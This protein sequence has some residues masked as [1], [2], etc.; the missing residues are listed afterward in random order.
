LQLGAV[1]AAGEFGH[2]K[3]PAGRR[4]AV[5][6]AGD[7]GC[8]EAIAKAAGRW[9][10][11][12]GPTAAPSGHMRDVVE[13][14]NSGDADDSPDDPRQ[15]PPRRRSPCRRGNLLNRSAWCGRGIWWAPMTSRGG[16]A[17]KR[18][19]ANRNC[20]GHPGAAGGAVDV[21]ATAPLSSAAPRWCF[22]HV[23]RP[24]RDRRVAAATPV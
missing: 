24:R 8:L 7:T 1:Q 5:P 14:A 18:C 2:N 10:A 16:S 6:A 17:E 22:D 4:S 23:L 21:M 13:L 9:S 20:V 12:C 19:T 15:R 3:T 11:H